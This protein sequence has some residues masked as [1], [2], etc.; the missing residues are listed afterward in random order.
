M[1]RSIPKAFT[2]CL[3]TICF[4]SIGWA[5]TDNT[6]LRDRPG[7]APTPGSSGTG[8]YGTPSSSHT[9]R[10]GEPV[11]L[12]KLMNSSLKSQSGES[13]GQ[14]Q[15]IIVDPSNGQIQFAVLS[16]NSSSTGTPTTSGI[17]TTTTPGISTPPGAIAGG[18]LVALPWRLVSS[19]GQGQFT[20]SVDRTTLQNAPTFSSSSWPTMNST[21]MQSVYS[22][23][24]VSPS[25][26]TGAPGSSSGTGTGTGTGTGLGN[27]S[28]P[29]APSSPGT[30]DISYPG[31]TRPPNTTPTPGTT[32]S[33]GSGSGAGT[34]SG[35]K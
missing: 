24:G 25:S 3:T 7:A 10:A 8:I 30:P 27:P 21:W 12:S 16:V 23:F 26:S 11:R 34:G 1:K 14:V 6:T 4:A 17:G 29:G 28:T 2:L 18:Q 5:Q 9:A 22:H 31:G 20:A 35:G 33:A 13:L 32:P 15:D 19:S